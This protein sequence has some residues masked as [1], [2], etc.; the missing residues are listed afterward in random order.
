MVGWWIWYSAPILA[1]IRCNSYSQ[2]WSLSSR[3]RSILNSFDQV[4]IPTLLFAVW[5]SIQ[6]REIAVHFAIDHRHLPLHFHINF[7][8]AMFD[9]EGS[10]LT[11]FLRVRHYLTVPSDHRKLVKPE[12]TGVGMISAADTPDNWIKRT[13]RWSSLLLERK[14]FIVS[15]KE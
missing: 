11:F 2:I 6:A 7:S 12:K 4:S 5:C 9:R 14:K 10:S 13:H 1:P 15:W 3:V 8:V